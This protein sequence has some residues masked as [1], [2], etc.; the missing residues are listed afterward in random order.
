MNAKEGTGSS[1]QT[2]PGA[3]SSF[4]SRPGAQHLSLLLDGVTIAALAVHLALFLIIANRDSAPW[5][6]G[7]DTG[8]YI[9][10][11]QNLSI[12]RGYTFAG[13][14]TAF[15]A[16]MYPMLLARLMRLWPSRWRLLL[17]AIQLCGTICTAVACGALA[18]K[19]GGQ[20]RVAFLFGLLMP[21]LLFFQTE[22]LTECIAALL[23]ALWWLY[24]CKSLELRGQ[25][26]AAIAG[27]CAGVTSLERF[28][29]IPLILLGPVFIYLVCRDHKRALLALGAG[30]I[31]VAPWFVH[32]WRAFGQ[33]LYSTHT[34][35]GLVEGVLSPTGRG[36]S[37]EI[38]AMRS[39][40]GWYNADVESNSAPPN[41]RNE[42]TL[43][44]QARRLSRDLWVG[45]GFTD[46]LKLGTIKLGAFWFSTDQ[47]L[48]TRTF[49]QKVRI[50]RWGGVAVYWIFVALAVVGWFYLLRTNSAMA[51]LLL[52]FVVSITALHLPLT[53]N[54]RLRVPFFEPLVVT[55]AAVGVSAL[56]SRRFFENPFLR[57]KDK[58]TS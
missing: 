24:L 15:R 30:C 29:A 58:F 11:A 39:K 4:D 35:F 9:S 17:R 19:W 51:W 6:G 40:L 20:E 7:A 3:S 1:R 41:L 32:N 14:P 42:L 5:S 21:T 2:G 50:L 38:A 27:I 25:F 43:D 8:I 54:T 52:A 23:V 37:A 36:D 56:E 34:G 49:S 31:I 12:G 33:P 28:N 47:I 57:L 45:Q 55:L 46:L 16:P 48:S 26:P 10:L 44:S 53:M 22:I 18:K 13:T